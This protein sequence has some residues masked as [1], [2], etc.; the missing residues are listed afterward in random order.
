MGLWTRIQAA[1]R[2]LATP[3]QSPRIRG[4]NLHEGAAQTRRLKGWQPTAAEINT[5]LQGGGNL[6]VRRARELCAVNPYAISAQETFTSHLV[7][8]GIQAASTLADDD[9]RV[10][11]N[12]LW[13]TWWDQA[14]ADG[15]NSL[16]GLMAMIGNELFEAGEIFF[17]RRS[18][19]PEDGL[20]V[21]LQL[22]PL[23]AE[24]LDRTY[25]RALGNGNSIKSGIEFN[26]IGK[27][28]G[29]WFWK[30][31]PGDSISPRRSIERVFVPAEQVLHI[32]VAKKAGQ[33]RGMPR[34][35]GGM[36][37]AK[38]LDDFEDATLDRQKVAA[39]LAGFIRRPDDEE[40]ALGNPATES[41]SD[42]T[43]DGTD[44]GIVMQEW[45]PGT[46]YTLD[47]GEE[48][49][50]PSLPEV[51]STYEPFVYR[52]LLRL[53]SAWGVPYSGLC[54]DFSKA[55]YSSLRAAMLELQRRIIPLQVNVVLFQFCRPVR[56]WFIEQA[57]LSGALRGDADE[58]VQYTK[59]IMPKWPWVDPLKDLQAE[60]LAVEKGFKARSDVMEAEGRDPEETDERI[61]QDQRRA[62]AKGLSFQA[63][64]G[65][66]TATPASDE[67][68]DTATDDEEQQAPQRRRSA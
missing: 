9:Q 54:A 52:Q 14:D 22:Q 21:P 66:Q 65:A 5:I 45:Q 40:G 41:L 11:V 56:R 53:A 57:V 44:D 18:R 47:V 42:A 17:R 68:D 34:I 4:T 49:D 64:S 35:A 13:K 31:H 24:Y 37:A 63:D 33:I 43:S 59:W 26:R 2:L 12:A 30:S 15:T 39:M 36:V 3:E 46:L 23:P 7:G 6:I 67:E 48:I 38:H 19:L 51:G 29:Y 20:A 27:R 25:T 61:A 58:L 50:F 1:A 32:Y 10:A 28:V 60:T 16:G 62:Q 8:S 55:N